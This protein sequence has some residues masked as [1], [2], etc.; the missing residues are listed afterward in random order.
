[1]NMPN[2]LRLR[3][4]V[5]LAGLSS[6]ALLPLA[7]AKVDQ[8]PFGTANGKPV[9]LFVLTNPSGLVAKV[10]TYGA[11]L[12]ELDVPD[13]AGKLDDVVLGFDSI[14][15]YLAKEPYFGATVG[16][17]GNRI[18]KGR[19]TL[20]GKTYQLATNDGPN[21]L[22]GGLRGFDKVIWDGAVV[23][24]DAPS[25]RFTYLSPDGEEGYP[26]N[27]K[28]S[29]TYTL[30]P[31]QGLK[32]TYVVTT[33]K[34]TPIN[35]TNHSYF[36]LGGAENGDILD[37]SIKINADRYT[38]VDATLIPTGELKPVA[39][40]PMDFRVSTR[41][42]LHLKEVGGN[43]EGYDHN[44]VV[45][46]SEHA[47]GPSFVAEV[48]DP[49]SGRT[50]HVTST[51]PGV[52]FYTGNFLDGTLTGKKGVVYKQHWGLCLETQHFPD[53][54]NQPTFPSSILKAGTTH[55]SVTVYRFTA[56]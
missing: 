36:N 17:V 46:R 24:G 28:V 43:P 2:P 1:M 20:N 29:V 54:V 51:E 31:S 38:P 25:V 53:S 23:P 34:D 21:S 45:N 33:D 41:I 14:D 48:T 9:T 47:A 22:H 4:L 49:K 15:G 11:T 30:T 26:G 44:F 10:M 55:L 56:K 7:Q 13:R 37:H 40:T 52:Q 19:F 3:N 32:L 5:A 50:M 39:G 35:V 12:T 8:V 18:A 16:R 27:C 6:S 42:G